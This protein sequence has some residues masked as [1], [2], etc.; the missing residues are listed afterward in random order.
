[1][2]VEMQAPKVVPIGDLPY[3]EVRIQQIQSVGPSTLSPNFVYWLA[4]Q[5]T[6]LLARRLEKRGDH[7][8][9]R[10]LDTLIM[11]YLLHAQ[12]RK[13]GRLKGLDDENLV[14]VVGEATYLINFYEEVGE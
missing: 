2:L 3:K 6:D 9:A 1:M 4:K 13:D 14:G 12:I 10:I 8:G 11:L 5:L 7:K